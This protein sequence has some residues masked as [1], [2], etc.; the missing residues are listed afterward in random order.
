MKELDVKVRGD[1]VTAELRV[2]GVPIA[3]RK[4]SIQDIAY[5][6]SFRDVVYVVASS[7]GRTT[8]YVL[9]PLAEAPLRKETIQGQLKDIYTKDGNLVIKVSE[10]TVYVRPMVPVLSV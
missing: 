2:F 10:G 4:W 1:V 3:M 6:D 7:H 8:I 9:S 5:V